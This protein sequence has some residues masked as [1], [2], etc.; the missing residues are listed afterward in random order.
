MRVSECQ[1]DTICDIL[2]VCTL[3]RY[4]YNNNDNKDDYSVRNQRASLR[5]HCSITRGRDMIC[6]I[7]E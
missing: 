2:L 4:G 1:A 3:G 6:G 5:R 7:W